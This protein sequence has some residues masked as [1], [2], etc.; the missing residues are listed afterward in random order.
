MVDKDGTTVTMTEHAELVKR[1]SEVSLDDYSAVYATWFDIDGYAKALKRNTKGFMSGNE[2]LRR[3]ERALGIAVKRG[4]ER[5]LINQGNGSR[6]AKKDTIPIRHDRM[7]DFYK[8]A[9]LTDEDFEKVLVNARDRGSL[10]RSVVLE[11][12][13]ELHPKPAPAPKPLGTARGR[14]TLE[15]LAIQVNSI[16]LGVQE[17]GPEEVSPDLQD[18]V[19]QAFKDIGMIRSWLRKVNDHASKT[20]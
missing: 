20:A 10:G 9:A 2:L 16:A 12:I 11:E 6:Y 19:D 3:A 7:S 14:R 15:H 18:I 5:G 17:I 13:D 8:L 1:L 4:Q